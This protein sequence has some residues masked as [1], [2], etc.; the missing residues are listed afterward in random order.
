LG[1][2]RDGEGS[3]RLRTSRGQRSKSNQEEVESRERN[4]VDSQFSQVRVELTRESETAGNAR[5][6]SRDQVVQVTI[7]GSGEFEGSEADIVQGF[8]IN[9]HDFISVFN[10]LVDREGGIVRFNDSV[11]DLGGW[12]NREGAHHSV[13][14]FFSNL[15]D[16]EGTHTRS[17]SSSQRV[18]DLETLEAIARFGFF[19][20][21]VQDGV[22]QFS[23]FGVV[24]LGPVVTS[25]SLSKDKVVGSKELSI[26][27]S[28]DGI[29][30]SRFEINKDGSRHVFASS[31]FV[32]VNVDSFQLE[33]RV[34]VVCSSGVD[35]MF[36]RDDF[37]ELGSNLVTALTGLDVDNFSHL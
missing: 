15:G 35:S 4:Q 5:H 20:D 37:P 23:S 11:R 24:S 9:A 25:S 29:H 6:N 31:G 16:Q 3:V 30:G 28:S 10:Q 1:E 7:S 13:G 33:V 22:D 19:S 17:S 36:V 21:D 34:S 26:R 32:V 8:V 27:S 14:V 12:H 18:S 2:F